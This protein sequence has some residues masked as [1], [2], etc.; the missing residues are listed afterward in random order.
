MYSIQQEAF[1]SERRKEAI[2]M[3]DIEK[4]RLFCK[5][6]RIGQMLRNA[7]LAYIKESAQ[8]RHFPGT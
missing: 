5:L 1:E 7:K 2:L 6:A 3:S 8:N 4:F